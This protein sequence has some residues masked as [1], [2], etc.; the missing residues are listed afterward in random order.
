MPPNLSFESAATCPTVFI[1]VDTAFRQAAGCRPGERVLVHGAAGGVGLA[2]IQQAAA[3]G[4]VVVATAGGPNKRSLVRGMGVAHAFGFAGHALRVGYRGDAGRRRHRAQQP[5]VE[6]LCVRVAVG[7]PSRR[8]L[9]R[10][11]QARHLERGSGVPGASRTFGYTL[12]AVDFLPDMAVQRALVRLGG[13]LSEGVVN[14][15]PQ[16]DAPPVRRAGGAQADV[17]GSSRG[18]DREPQALPG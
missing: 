1:T 8:S 14:P 6:R 2:A 15:L 7:A 5:D 11:Q 9:H 12:V 10:D 4:G 3:L 16:V 18:Q 17:A 13:L